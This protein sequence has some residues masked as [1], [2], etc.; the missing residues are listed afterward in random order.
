MINENILYSMENLLRNSGEKELIYL[1]ACL[2][3]FAVIL[4][5]MQH[6]KSTI[7]Q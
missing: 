5:L 6:Y 2:I 7:L 1:Y 3:H 4:R